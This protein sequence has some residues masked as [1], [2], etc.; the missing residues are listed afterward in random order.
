[1]D[2]IKMSIELLNVICAVLDYRRFISS[3]QMVFKNDNYDWFAE[4]ERYF[5]TLPLP[6]GMTH[7][8]ITFERILGYGANTERLNK[9]NN[10]EYCDLEKEWF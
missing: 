1:M 4:T 10:T 2:K 9:L 5:N 3:N 7:N 6:D 8:R